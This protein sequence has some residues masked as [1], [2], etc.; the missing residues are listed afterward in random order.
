MCFS[1]NKN[2]NLLAYGNKCLSIYNTPLKQVQNISFLG[3][4]LDKNLSWKWHMLIV[5]KKLRSY[6]GI[7]SRLKYHLNIKNLIQI[8]HSLIE[9]Q[10]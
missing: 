10:I 4:Y 2:N 6:L 3:L 9:S 8:Y 1:S 7:I 5:I